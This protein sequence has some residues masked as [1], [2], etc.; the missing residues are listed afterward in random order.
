MSVLCELYTTSNWDF[1]NFIF[2]WQA[3]S[4]RCFDVRCDKCKIHLKRENHFVRLDHL[5]IPVLSYLGCF[6]SC[7][8]TS[9]PRSHQTQLLVLTQSMATPGNLPIQTLMFYP[10]WPWLMDQIVI[11][12]A[13]LSIWLSNFYLTGNNH[14][15][16]YPTLL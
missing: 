10:L 4:S 7:T 12:S 6:F 16:T 15:S 9:T 2:K 8:V 5:V 14:Y 11:L 13:F 3:A 1:Y